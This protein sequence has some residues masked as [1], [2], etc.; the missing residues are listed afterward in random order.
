MMNFVFLHSPAPPGMRRERKSL[1]L[2]R[3]KR[4]VEDVLIF[5]FYFPLLYSGLIGNKF[6]WFPQVESVLLVMVNAGWCLPALILTQEPFHIFSPLHSRGGQWQSSFGGHPPPNPGSTK[7]FHCHVSGTEKW[8]G[9]LGYGNDR[10][11]NREAVRLSSI[12]SQAA[13]ESRVSIFR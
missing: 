6:I 4:R 1:S 3:E 12:C 2:G 10:L 8:Y 13:S 9:K 7:D 5:G 11:C